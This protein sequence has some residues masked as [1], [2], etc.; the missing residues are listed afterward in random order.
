MSPRPARVQLLAL[1]GTIACVPSR[2]GLVPRL[3][4]ADLVAA[5]RPPGRLQIDARNPLRRTILYPEDWATLSELIH[6]ERARYD[7][8]VLTLGTDT[9]AHAACALSLMLQRLAIPVVLTG[10]MQPIRG[11]GGAPARRNLRDALQ[12][13]RSGAAGVFV[14]FHGKVIDGRRATKIRSDDDDAF[15]SVNAPP[16]ATIRQGRLR[17]R[18]K[19][20]AHAG[21]ARLRTT[22]NTNVALAELTPQT[23]A[24]CLAHL[25]RYDGVVVAGYG[26]G[27]VSDNLIDRLKSLAREGLVVLASQC[28]FGAVHHRYAGGAALVKA[29]ALSAGD[30]STEMACVKLM[31]SLGQARSARSA[32]RLFRTA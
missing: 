23:T 2:A 15:D 32:R 18:H 6:A 25:D 9:L 28:A 30:L 27:N 13:A 5:V 14:V 31:W 21:A 12:V 24:R 11:P 16:L 8:V 20:V 3:E 7:G 17:W 29:G 4:A 1:G 26:D 22:L 19:P 10:S